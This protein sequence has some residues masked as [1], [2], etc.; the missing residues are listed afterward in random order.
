[1]KT[2]ILAKDKWWELEKRLNQLIPETEADPAFW[3]AVENNEVKLKAVLSKYGVPEEDW[4]V[5]WH[6]FRCRVLYCY[7]YADRV[8]DAKLL[9]KISALLPHDGRPWYAQLECYTDSKRAPNGGPD[10]LG[11]IILYE[12]VAYLC[13]DDELTKRPELIELA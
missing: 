5:P 7:I 4:E 9:A 8:Y 11:M 2:V 1:M 3:R 6:R 10:T 12:D 13:S